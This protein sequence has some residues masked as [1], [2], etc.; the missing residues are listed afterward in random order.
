[1]SF[2]VK[3]LPAHRLAQ[4]PAAAARR[5]RFLWSRGVGRGAILDAFVSCGRDCEFGLFQ[6]AH[7][8]HSLSLLKFARLPNE[9]LPTLIDT[10]LDEL[11]AGAS[12]LELDPRPRGPN[13]PVEY[14]VIAPR[15][16]LELHTAQNIDAFTPEAVLATQRGRLALLARKMADDLDEGRKIF[17]CKSP[18]APDAAI[19]RAA[20]DAVHRRGGGALLWVTEAAEPG[21]VGA[22]A[23]RGQGLFHGFVDSF[24]Y[25]EGLH[26]ISHEAWLALCYNAA[27]LIG[28]GAGRRAA[29]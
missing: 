16:S 23:S 8:A 7:G 6:N 1:M 10:G 28:Q 22:V 9:A 17:V 25:D 12:T 20:A 29:S 11:A 4:L 24:A 2:S 5:S 21:D 15:Y 27:R 18:K 14:V 26:T 13:G 19:P 3:G